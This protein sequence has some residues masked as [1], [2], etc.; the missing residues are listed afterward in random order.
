MTLTISEYQDTSKREL[1]RVL[2][3]GFALTQK[4]L[5]TCS[6]SELT[7]SLH[8]QAPISPLRP[9][10]SPCAPAR[11]RRLACLLAIA[12]TEYSTGPTVGCSGLLGHPGAWKN[13]AGTVARNT[14]LFR[15]ARRRTER[16]S[17][18]RSPLVQRGGSKGGCGCHLVGGCEALQR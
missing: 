13:D 17:T 6:S 2:K 12:S 3:N 16:R 1:M 7:H 18:G 11:R 4:R 10:R 8:L 14:P 9:P 5:Q 15:S